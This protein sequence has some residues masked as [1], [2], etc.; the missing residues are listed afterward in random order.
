MTCLG[1]SVTTLI[2]LGLLSFVCGR[3][4]LV[5]GTFKLNNVDR[6]LCIRPDE[7]LA[8]RRKRQLNSLKPRAL[9]D[10][11]SAVVDKMVSVDGVAVFSLIY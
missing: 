9:R 1:L 2:R 4:L 5:N 11:K 8:D 7:S 6:T 3:R 10:G